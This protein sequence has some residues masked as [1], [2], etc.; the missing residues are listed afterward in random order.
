MLPFGRLILSMI[1]R[2]SSLQDDQG[3]DIVNH[4]IRYNLALEIALPRSPLGFRLDMGYQ[5]LHWTSYIAALP[6]DYEYWDV[7][8]GLEASYRIGSLT[9]V[10][11]LEAPLYPFVYPQL[12]SLAYPEASFFGQIIL[13]FRWTFPHHD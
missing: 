4:W 2:N 6:L 9:L 1:D 5:K 13:G 8:A 10:L 12:Q 11:G 3:L 7:Y